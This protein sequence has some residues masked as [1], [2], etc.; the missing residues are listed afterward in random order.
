MK[1]TAKYIELK[2][3]CIQMYIIRVKSDKNFDVES[4]FVD[5]YI[6]YC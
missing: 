1:K 4:D 5:C 3:N 2:L 6:L